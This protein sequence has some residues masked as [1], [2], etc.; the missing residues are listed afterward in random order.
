MANNADPEWRAGDPQRWS[1]YWQGWYKI[2]NAKA[3]MV[4]GHYNSEHIAKNELAAAVQEQVE[5]VQAL[6]LQVEITTWTVKERTRT[7][8]QTFPKNIVGESVI[9]DWHGTLREVNKKLAITEGKW[10][11]GSSGV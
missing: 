11:D 3:V 8:T 7:Q 5:K 9:C 4:G 1:T 10:H 6:G 2:G